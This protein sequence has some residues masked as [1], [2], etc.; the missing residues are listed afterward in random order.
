MTYYETFKKK[1]SEH[2]KDVS[3][4]ADCGG[5]YQYFTK[6]NHKQTTKHKNAIEFK[7]KNEE[8]NKLK[9]LLEKQKNNIKEISKTE[10][11]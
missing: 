3:I 7:K 9:E 2:L 4:C 10:K 1:H 5:K 11:V 6:H 8:I